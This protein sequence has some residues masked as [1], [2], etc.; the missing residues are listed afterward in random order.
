MPQLALYT[1][2]TLTAPLTDPGPLTRALYDVG[3]QVYRTITAHPG[4]LGH[5]EPVA[6]DRG[7]LFGADWGVWGEFVVPTWYEKGR[8]VESTALAATLSLWTDPRSAF[9]A[10]H[11]GPH[12]E[13]LNRRRDW[14][15]RAGHPNH[16]LWWT[17][18]GATPRWQ[19]GVSRLE[20][21]YEHGLAPDA[22]TFRRA[23]TPEGSPIGWN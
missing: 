23:F 1:F 16:V 6:A 21:L 22:F 11:T 15:E 13:A 5:A 14:F 19:D 20:H 8:T 9:D 18:D 2:G 10:V 4:Y 7:R 12:R 3:E 17:P